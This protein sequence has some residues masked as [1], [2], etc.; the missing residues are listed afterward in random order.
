MDSSVAQLGEVK[1]FQRL[2]S[3]HLDDLRRSGLSEETIARWGCYSI[4]ERSEIRS[5]GF[6]HVE[7]PAMALPI[8]P[9]DRIEPDATDV[10]LKPD[11]PRTDK[12]GHAAKYEARPNSRNRIHAP[13]AIRD[14]LS[15]VSVPLIIT[16]GQKK[17][18]KGAQAGICV[19]AL[20]GVWNWR[21]RIGESSF[22]ISD[23][24][25]F[26]LLSRRV[27]LCFDSDAVSNNHVRQA[28]RDLAAF[29]RKHFGTRVAVKRLPPGLDG[30]KVGLDDFLLTHT[31]EEFWALPEHEPTFD[32]HAGVFSATDWPEPAPLGDELPSVQSFD[33]ELLPSCFRP[34]IE[35]VSERMQAPP[36]FAAG[37]AIVTLAG[38]VN[39]RAAIHPKS[40]DDSWRV[41]PNLWGAIV[42][43][44]GFMKSPILR[45]ITQPLAQIEEL[46]RAEYAEESGEYQ[47]AK[48]QADLRLQAWREDYKRAMKKNTPAPVQP[49]NSLRPPAQRRLS[50]TDSTF[51]KMHEILS[52]NPAGLLVVRDELTGWLAELDKQGREG[53]RGFYLQGWNG[54][55]GY[56]VDRIGRGSI[57]VPAVC[58][59]LLGN[60]QPSRLRWFLSQ[61]FNGGPSDDGLFQR[62][63][64]LVWPDPPR[65]WHLI[66]RP[67]NGAALGAAEKI[68]SDLANLSVDDPVRMR[69][70]PESQLLFYEWLSELENK[71]RSDSGLPAP[72]VAHLAKYRSLMPTLAGLFELADLANEGAVHSEALISLDHARQAAALCDY[73][74]SHARRVYACVMSPECRAAR[75]LARHIQSG[76]LGPA[77]GT[78]SVYLKGWSGLDTPERVRGALHLLEDAGWLRR[79]ESPSQPAGGRPSEAWEINPKLVQ[80]E[81]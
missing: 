55:A 6:G 71:I 38:C 78:R 68:F 14:K 45:A 23:F 4:L 16:E 24:E 19:I 29:L 34:L 1:S 13:L 2:A 47:I 56:T 65:E 61:A 69:F 42:G 22:P 11:S 75:E 20:A 66:D 62:F 10:M 70:D 9:P 40:A 51:E 36:D 15:D 32:S 64:I 26:P 60:I 25:L 17:S 79:A 80:H 67:P 59:S 63:Q 54:D 7:P 39:R 8:L 33:L 27:L 53:E 48:E 44:P 18:E 41:V 77:F 50:L 74:E 81:K 76:D 58:I 35:D 73:L 52:E 28:E 72:F 37:A 31:A 49:D 30:G 12:R 21:D 43:Q 46:W 3:N 5:L 57:Y